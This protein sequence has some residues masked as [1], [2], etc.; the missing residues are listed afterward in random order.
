PYTSPK[1]VT[2]VIERYR[3][4]GLPSPIDGDVLLRA[5]VVS[6]SLIPR[7]LQ[8]LEVLDLID[9]E[10]KPTANLEGLRLASEAEY[11]SRMAEWLK[12]TYSDVFSFVDPS[13]DG[14]VAIRDAFRGYKPVGQQERMV[15]LFIGLCAVA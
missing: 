3:N 12:N 7:T 9:A 8:S 4:R 10:G 6:E 15:T 11:K 13:S 14:E 5:S 1:A 2:D